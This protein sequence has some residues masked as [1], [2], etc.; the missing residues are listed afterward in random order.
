MKK[1]VMTLALVLM[2]AFVATAQDKKADAPKPGP[3]PTETMP[4]V[5]AI[6]DKYVKALGGKEAD[7]IL[8][9]KVRN[10]A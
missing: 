6:L 2:A 9:E 7:V 5:D 3:K 8:S 10:D 1:I 4:T